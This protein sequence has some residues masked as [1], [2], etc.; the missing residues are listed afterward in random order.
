[1]TVAEAVGMEFL[2]TMTTTVPAG[3]SADEVDDV[4][5][6]EAANTAKLAAAGTVL[7]LWRPPLQPG[8][9]RTIGLFAAID[10]EDL[11]R[12][13]SSMPLRVWRSDQVTPL[14]AHPDDPGPGRVP[15]AAGSVEYLV[16]LTQA[17][18]APARPGRLR[19]LWTLPEPGRNLSLW[20]AADPS[21]LE[22]ILAGWPTTEIVPLTRHPSDPGD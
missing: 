12:T 14:G 16:T 4:R 5:A 10:G 3:T 9:W 11:E 20:Q 6:R 8:E 7:R 13:L 15:L 18:A 21:Q 1:M 19:R 17:E 22:Q 2:V